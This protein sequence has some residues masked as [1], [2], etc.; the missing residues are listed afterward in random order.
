MD[1][2]QFRAGADDDGSRTCSLLWWPGAKEKRAEHHDAE[3][4]DDVHHYGAVGAVWL[5]FV[6]W[7]RRKFYR[8]LA[9]YISAW[10]WRAARSGL[11]CHYPAADLHDLPVD[12]CHHHSGAYHR[13]FRGTDEIQRH[14]AVY[15]SMVGARLRSHGAHG[16]GQGWAAECRSRRPFPYSRFRRWN[17]GSYHVGSFGFSL[18]SLSGTPRWLSQ[19]TDAAA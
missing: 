7:R 10:R 12:V 3:F 19:R 13:R 9:Q 14:G 16:L 2:D 1:A 5:Q 17:C 15:D 8:P 18:R 4:R 11:R 6:I